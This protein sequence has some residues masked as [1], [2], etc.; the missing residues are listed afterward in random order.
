MDEFDVGNSGVVV[1]SDE[2]F[3]F[4]DGACVVDIDV[5]GEGLLF[6]GSLEEEFYHLNNY[7]IGYSEYL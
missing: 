3:E 6:G 4:R 1:V 7:Q 5:Q 2:L